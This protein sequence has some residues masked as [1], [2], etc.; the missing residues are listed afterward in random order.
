MPRVIAIGGTEK[1][2]PPARRSSEWAMIVSI[3]S[4]RTRVRD[5]RSISSVTSVQRLAGDC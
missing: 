5:A 1:T 2:L 3:A 4:G